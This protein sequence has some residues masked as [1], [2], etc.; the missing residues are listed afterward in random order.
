MYTFFFF[1]PVRKISGQ[2]YARL[3]RLPL[4]WVTYKLRPTA[5]VVEIVKRYPKSTTS[6]VAPNQIHTTDETAMKI[7]YDRSTI[8]SRFYANMALGK[9]SNRLSDLLIIPVQRPHETT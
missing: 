1:S 6:V 8:K 3:S 7:S 2:W 5:W 4:L 9:M